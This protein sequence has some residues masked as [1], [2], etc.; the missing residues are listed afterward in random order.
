MEVHVLTLHVAE[1]DLDALAA[2]LLPPDAPLEDVSFQIR[3]E[4]ICVKGV[5][6]L[7]VNVA[8]ESWWQIRVENGKVSAN[9]SKLKAFGMPAMVFKSAVLKSLH[10]LSAREYWFEV[11]GEEVHL[12]ID[13][14]LS[15]FACPGRMHL[16]SIVCGTGIVVVEAGKMAH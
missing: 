9:M 13:Y 10:E 1:T 12:D 8:F 16:R 5:Y 7:L 3:P 6:P 14:L 4:G 2:K 11:K 15:R